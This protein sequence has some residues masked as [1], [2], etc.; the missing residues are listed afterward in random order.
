MKRK[1]LLSIALCV[2]LLASV[3]PM[4]VQAADSFTVDGLSYSVNDGMSVTLT[5][6]DESCSGELTVPETV[7]NGETT[8]TVTKVGADAFYQN[9]RITGVALPESVTSI[10]EAAFAESGLTG[11]AFPTGVTEVPDM[12]FSGCQS[13]SSVALSP[14]TTT[15]GIEAFVRTP[16]LTELKLPTA[17]VS[18]R[19]NAFDPQNGGEPPILTLY[20]MGTSMDWAGVTYYFSEEDVPNIQRPDEPILQVAAI[21]YHD[22]CDFSNGGIC[23]CGKSVAASVTL[24]DGTTTTH[25]E[26][27]TEALEHVSVANGGD[28]AGCTV[29]LLRSV[30]EPVVTLSG[31]GVNCTVDLGGHTFTSSNSDGFQIHTNAVVTVQNGTVTAQNSGGVRANTGAQVTLKNV[32][33]ST[34]ELVGG[35]K[36]LMDGDCSLSHVLLEDGE[37]RLDGAP[38]IAGFNGS[39]I[40]VTGGMVTVNGELGGT[41]YKV[42]GVSGV[43][44]P[45]PFAQ[46]GSG[47]TLNPQNFRS[48]VEGYYVGRNVNGGLSLFPGTCS[49]TEA[50]NDGFCDVC[51]AAFMAKVTDTAGSSLYT[52]AMEA[53]R[54]WTDGTAAGPKTLTLLQNSEWTAVTSYIELP[55]AERVL[56]LNGCTLKAGWG[57]QIGSSS[58][59]VQDSSSGQT[60][61]YQGKISLRAAGGSLTLSGGTLDGTTDNAISVAPKVTGCSITVSGGTVSGGGDCI[62]AQA[63]TVIRLQGGSV[64]NTSTSG[65][66]NNAID[67]GV[68]T[69]EGDAAVSM[70]SPSHTAMN[71]CSVTVSGAPAIT[72]AIE[73]SSGHTL[74]LGGYTGDGLD[75]F[76]DTAYNGDNSIKLSQEY[77]LFQNGEQTM[78]IPN[79]VATVKRIHEHSWSFSAEDA[80]ITATC[81]GSGK[82]PVENGTAIITLTAPGPNPVYDGHRQDCTVVQSVPGLFPDVDESDVYTLPTMNIPWRP[83]TIPQDLLMG[84]LR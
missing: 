74:D 29:R 44:Y 38:A 20:Y 78:E 19:M 2:L 32:K 69:M 61:V 47:I 24:A 58:L 68:V 79:G 48:A 5:G 42:S 1:R 50:D 64:T 31:A 77:G 35:A 75:I 27:L 16:A 33:T 17:L 8:Y 55:A 84:T 4:P 80:V 26:T 40:V 34:V 12:C 18:I 57:I 23:I 21:M 3:L 41:V 70:T 62:V 63:D 73:Y 9:T 22:A 56:D 28:Y 66:E 83:V 6:A 81:G 46:A 30:T 82:C 76:F 71:G 37:L 51:G 54:A 39:Q 15:I 11:F 52:D 10:G 25:Y 59:L 36:I 14:D 45:L 53:I 7:T 65:G 72:G 43:E 67:G 60:G 49:H 13:L